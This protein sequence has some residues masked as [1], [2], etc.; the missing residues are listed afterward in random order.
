METTILIGVSL[1]IPAFAFW[2]NWVVRL[3]MGYALS[4]AADFI[5]AVAT[6]D[7]GAIAGHHVF[8]KAMNATVFQRDFVE[9]FIC[10]LIISLVAWWA[11]FLRLEDKITRLRR[12]GASASEQGKVKPLTVL[13]WMLV[14]AVMFPHAFA[15]LYK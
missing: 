10:L 8:E 2:I 4:A 5:L 6:F 13:S 7:L 14:A 9:L 3:N 1:A 12:P 11:C 15:F